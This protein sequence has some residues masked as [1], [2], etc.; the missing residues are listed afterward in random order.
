MKKEIR[1]TDE[2]VKIG[3]IVPDFLPKP[4]DLVLR[5]SNVRVTLNLSN[6]SLTFFREL[7][8]QS[9]VPYQKLIRR[10]LDEFAHEARRKGMKSA[11]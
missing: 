10:Y 4:Q 11:R 9:R 5:E 1:Y 2:P 7:G 8:R 6:A 3:R